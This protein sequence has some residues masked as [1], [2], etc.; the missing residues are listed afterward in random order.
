MD[1][2]TSRAR[3]AAQAIIDIVVA[4]LKAAL[5]DG[6]DRAVGKIRQR[7]EDR[8]LDEIEAAEKRA[9]SV[10]YDIPF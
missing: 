8:I 10:D 9:Q 2:Q 5:R 7:I 6:D 4:G 3:D 1:R